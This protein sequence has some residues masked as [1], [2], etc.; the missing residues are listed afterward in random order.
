MD[1][2]FLNAIANNESVGQFTTTQAQG[3][4]AAKIANLQSSGDLMD[5]VSGGVLLSGGIAGKATGATETALKSFQTLSKNV[6]N[7]VST[8][9]QNA[10]DNVNSITNRVNNIRNPEPNGTAQ[11]QIMDT[12]PESG[13]SGLVSDE[14]TNVATNVGTNV[15]E[16][17]GTDLAVD[18]TADAVGA[19][20]TASGIGAPLGAAL[21][22]G[23][24]LVTGILGIKDLVDSH[25]TSPPKPDVT[26]IP[27]AMF[28]PGVNN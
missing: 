5:T 26:S 13:V 28:A 16:D 7:Q 11:D 1:N 18:A 23:T 22:L 27:Q 21:I 12:D 14:A 4:R 17:V 24:S 9:L 15:A 19:G 10:R 25:H 20:L 2:N 6:G 3:A 8:T